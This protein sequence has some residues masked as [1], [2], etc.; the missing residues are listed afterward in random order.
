M[1]IRKKA[2]DRRIPVAEQMEASLAQEG[3]ISLSMTIRLRNGETGQWGQ[4]T[5][6]SLQVQT[7]TVAAAQEFTQKLR[8]AGIRIAREMGLAIPGVIFMDK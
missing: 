6:V 3:F 4:Y 7:Q 2:V 1:S 5:G 8:E